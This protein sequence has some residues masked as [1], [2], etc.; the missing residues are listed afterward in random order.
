M[1]LALLYSFCHILNKYVS[2]SCAYVFVFLCSFFFIFAFLINH[3]YTPPQTFTHRFTHRFGNSGIC[4]KPHPPT[5]MLV[6]SVCTPLHTPTHR[7]AIHLALLG[8]C[9]FNNIVPCASIGHHAKTLAHTH[10]RM[11]ISFAHL[12]DNKQASTATQRKQ[13]CT[14]C[15]HWTPWQ[16]IST[17]THTHMRI[18]LA[19]LCDNK[20]ASTAT[21]RNTM[22]RQG[23]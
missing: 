12:C 3:V 5:Q 7:F 14:L 10:T 15:E 22:Q 1:V 16:N 2:G 4:C 13:H 8:V 19:H 18:S 20:Q 17:R 21:Q 9:G 6:L 11:R 23:L